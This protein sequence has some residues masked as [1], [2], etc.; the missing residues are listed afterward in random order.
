MWYSGKANLNRLGGG[1]NSVVGFSINIMPPEFFTGSNWSLIPLL[2]S[3]TV[4]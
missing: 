2:P 1:T 3:G 4:R